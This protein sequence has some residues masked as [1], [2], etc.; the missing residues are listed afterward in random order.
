MSSPSSPSLIFLWTKGHH[1]WQTQ[2]ASSKEGSDNS[3]G[4]D[5]SRDPCLP[6]PN[7]KPII[8]FVAPTSATFHLWNP[9]QGAAVL[10]LTPPGG[11]ARENHHSEERNKNPTQK[12]LM[13]WS[14]LLCSDFYIH[15]FYTPNL[16][17]RN[18]LI[19]FWSTCSVSPPT[20]R[21]QNSWQANIVWRDS[22]GSNMR[23]SL[24]FSN[25]V[26][27]QRGSW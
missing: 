21:S 12:D 5:V 2:G 13:I 25:S 24:C 20:G 26:L 7:G 27:T 23:F 6:P 8:P 4:L 10:M 19:C 14:H 15:R 3:Q 22:E 18:K 11:G 9:K 1:F 17:K 16:H